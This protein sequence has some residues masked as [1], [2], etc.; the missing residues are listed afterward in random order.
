MFKSASAP[1]TLQGDQNGIETR[2]RASTRVDH[3]IGKLALAA[4]LLTCACP[5]WA[6]TRDQAKRM[7]DRIAGVPPSTATLNTMEAM[8]TGGDELGAAL[9]ATQAPE[10]Y[11][12]TLKNHVAPW[13]NRDADIFV[14]LNDYTATVIGL[15]RDDADFRDVLSGDVLYLGSGS[16]VPAYN[17]N[18]NAHHEA[19][20]ATGADLKTVLAPVTQ[21]SVSPLPAD[22]TAGV[23]TTRQAARAFFIDG[24][25]RA[26]LRFTLM[27]H[28]CHDLE[29]LQDT[30]RAPD[31]IRQDVS[32]SP[33][34][35]SRV[36]LNNCIGCHSG[37]DPLAQGF[38]YYDFVYDRAN[39]PAAVTG[40]IN[41][42][43]A[44][45]TDPATGTRVES[46]YFNNNTTFE[47]GFVTPNDRWS[48]Y[49]RAGAN[50]LL[51][52][53]QSLPGQGSGAKSLG[54]ELAN[55]EAFATCHVE[56]VFTNVCLRPPQ[57]SADHTQIDAMTGSF[58]ANGYNLR[59]VF[60]ESATY[61]MGD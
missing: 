31:R 56:K 5:S 41:Y 18:N 8:I 19:L 42:N 4:L 22:A 59:R 26:M 53:D 17:P 30:S 58:K 44:G 33:G 34:G 29:Q 52:W 57:D 13:T 23:M 20:E 38:A 15:V 25:N 28:L 10:F 37:M 61:C 12:V 32:R 50:A 11:S 46:K 51:E 54:L 49:W 60:A 27:N 3:R 43:G 16:G 47:P 1:L 21:S 14:P 39:D 35:D 40:T 45:T 36:F 55:S 7:H 9:L 6:T 2:K 24:T 48:N